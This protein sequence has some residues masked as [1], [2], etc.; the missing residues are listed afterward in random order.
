MP[1]LTTEWANPSSAHRFGAKLKSVIETACEQV[2]EP[3]G[4]SYAIIGMTKLARKLVVW[5][6]GQ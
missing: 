6:Q 4:L 1:Y 2:A 3:I 5:Y